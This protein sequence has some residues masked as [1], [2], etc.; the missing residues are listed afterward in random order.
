MHFERSSPQTDACA[1]VDSEGSA[2]QDPVTP[3]KEEPGDA[4]VGDFALRAVTTSDWS[5]ES[6]EPMSLPLAGSVRT[7]C[8][9]SSNAYLIH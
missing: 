1:S 7:F 3:I 6:E 4:T 2:A 8:G 5:M 9:L